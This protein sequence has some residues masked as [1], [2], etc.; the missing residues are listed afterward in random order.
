MVNN[1]VIHYCKNSYLSIRIVIQI[2]LSAIR[3]KN[4]FFFFY[5]Q[6]TGANGQISIP[7]TET[8]S[9]SARKPTRMASGLRLFETGPNIGQTVIIHEVATM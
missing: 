7:N 9:K 2:K 4:I 1:F 3:V 8:I 6:H 5:T